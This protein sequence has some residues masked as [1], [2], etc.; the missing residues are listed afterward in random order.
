MV[1]TYQM[2]TTPGKS[3]PESYGNER[4]LHIPQN[5]SVTGAS[6]SDCLVSY[7]GHTVGLRDYPSA[8]MQLVCSTAPADWAW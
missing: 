1:E 8:E 3:R 2:H 6:P 5:S 4:L 7:P